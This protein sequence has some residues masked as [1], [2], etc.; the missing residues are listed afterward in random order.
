MVNKVAYKSLTK[1]KVSY[2]AVDNRGHVL[3]THQLFPIDIGRAKRYY[4]FTGYLSSYWLALCESS[5]TI[6]IL[7]ENQI[8]GIVL[9]E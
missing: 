1:D 5:S 3:L 2:A 4:N 6:I 8:A 9:Y 7:P